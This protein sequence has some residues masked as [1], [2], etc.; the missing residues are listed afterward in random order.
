MPTLEGQWIEHD[1]KGCPV[2]AGTRVEVRY[3]EPRS[4]DR[5]EV[6]ETKAGAL[7]SWPDARPNYNPDNDIVAYRL[8]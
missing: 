1:G 3:R 8:A 7:W 6:F 2:A 5:N 4:T